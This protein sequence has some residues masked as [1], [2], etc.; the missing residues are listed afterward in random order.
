MLA[1]CVKYLEKR[2][3]WTTFSLEIFAYCGQ[4]TLDFLSAFLVLEIGRV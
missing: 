3:H 2:R 1:I 4:V